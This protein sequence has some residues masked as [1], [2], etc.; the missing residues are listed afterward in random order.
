M[1][2]TEAD[3]SRV[4][5]NLLVVFDAVMRERHVGRAAARLCL[6]ASAISHGLTRLRRLL[7]D[8]LFL[9]HPRGVVPT[10]RAAELAAP[11]AEI[12]DRVRG[13]VAIS[14][15]FD[16]RRSTRR[17]TI[18]ALDAVTTAV[19]PRLF[20][21]L[22]TSGPGIDLSVRLVMPHAVLADLDAR[23]A[24]LAIEPLA[25][26]P[27]RFVAAKLYDEEFAIAMRAG[28]PLGP[29]PTLAAYCAA[30]HVLVSVTG[31][32]SGNVDLE[33][34]KLGRTRRVAATAP[35]FLSALELVAHT[36]LVA[37]VPR[38]QAAAY[39]ASLG[40]ALV[41]PPAPLAP[42]TRSPISVIASR[43]AMA[44]DGVAWLFRT[45]CACMADAAPVSQPRRRDAA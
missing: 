25:E 11:I 2:Q 16:A 9:K 24:D 35:S 15:G 18:G 32:P 10:A 30:S 33:L 31:D 17:F 27:A 5:L 13:V 44:D 45:V 20:A 6:S 4:D 7:H 22:A 37:A 21:A 1:K 28:H 43:A 29:R 3:L 39:A 34:A 42:L 36:D 8:P 14:Q 12:L 41:E 40:I 23:Q 26:V 38:R 19:L